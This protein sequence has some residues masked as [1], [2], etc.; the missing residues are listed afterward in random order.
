MCSSDLVAGL[1]RIAD[2]TRFV[3]AD[4][5]AFTWGWAFSDDAPGNC[6]HMTRMASSQDGRNWFVRARFSREWV[7]ETMVRFVDSSGLKAALIP[8]TIG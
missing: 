1:F 5:A 6:F 8:V 4:A 3:R 7:G 2:T